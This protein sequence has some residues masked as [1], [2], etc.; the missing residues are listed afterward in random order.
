[1]AMEKVF[2]HKIVENKIYEEWE[3]NGAFQPK[4]GAKPFTILMPH[5]MPMPRSRWSWHVYSDDHHQMAKDADTLRS[6][7][8]GRD[9][10][11][12]KHNLCMKTSCKEG[13]SRL[14]FDKDLMTILPSL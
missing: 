13:K 10:A 5:Q 14:D 2:D 11:G 6:G 4:A 3:K 9:H 8:P 7:S 1:M 12:L